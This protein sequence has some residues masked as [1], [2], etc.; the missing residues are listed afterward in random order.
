MRKQ[1]IS[2][3]AFS[4]AIGFVPFSA[5]ADA[6]IAAKTQAEERANFEADRRDIL[7][8]AGNYD[9]RF[10]MQETTSWLKDYKPIA[11][12][13][14]G[15]YETIKVIED[16]VN[17]IV[18]QHLLVVD[19]EG[20]K[21]FVIKHWRQDWEYEPKQILTYRGLGQWLLEDVPEKMSKGRWSQTVYQVDDSPRYAGWGQFETQAGIRRWRS[22]WTWRPL[23]RR[24]AVR[25][26]IYDRYFAINRHQLTPNGWIHWQDNTKMGMIDGK[27]TAVVQESVLNTY[28][29]FDKYDVATADK[30]WDKTSLYWKNVRNIWAD[31][32]VKDGGVKLTEKAETGNTIAANLLQ[33]ADDILEGKID[34]KN[35]CD[36][37]RKLI[38]EQ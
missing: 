5:F 30:Y 12:K 25:H 14:S 33:L 17:K 10:D 22:N 11:A 23:A 32:I 6:P 37:A 24:D 15:G 7:A 31:K 4:F 38:M 20:G 8:M 36:K 19:G 35:A 2:L 29:K 3:F 9:V 26:P 28:T 13:T 18:L 16:S 34:T 1:F 27:L 21:S